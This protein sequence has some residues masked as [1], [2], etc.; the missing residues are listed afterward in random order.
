MRTGF[1]CRGFMKIEA[2]PCETDADGNVLF[3]ENGEPFLIESSRRVL[4]DWFPN[5][6]LDAGRNRMGTA[7]DWLNCCQV[8]T[9]NTN[10]LTTDTSLLGYVAGTSS[11]QETLSGAQ[12]STPYY[13]WKR[14]RY[15]F[16]VGTTAANLNEVGI[17][18]NTASGAYLFARARIVDPSGNPTTVTPLADEVLDVWYEIRYYPPLEDVTG[19]VSLNSVSYDYTIR[20]SEVN[21]SEYGSLIG[22]AIGEYSPGIGD[23]VDWIAYDGVL[24]TILQAP[25]GTSTSG[26]D[27]PTND[28]YSNNSYQR[29]MVVS[30]DPT[31]WN[32]GAFIRSIRIKTTAGRFQTQF[33]ATS[34]GGPIPKDVNF[35]MIM[36]WIISWSA[37]QVSSDWTML[38]ASDTTFPTDGEW[39]MNLSNNVLR[40]GWN[41]LSADN[42]RL[43]LRSETGTIYRIV[44]QVDPTKWVEY[45][46]TGAYTEF[47]DYTTCPVT[48]SNI[49]NGGPTVGNTCTIRN[50][51]A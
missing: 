35:T 43:G 48:Q 4:A 15:R 47:G 50:T 41:D 29:R 26:S 1:H 30:C 46:V 20:A 42:Q 44:D 12:A 16:T 21:N 3:D 49:N 27:D 19:T 5:R 33:A 40:I 10:P 18:W 45:T 28:A 51:K 11:I 9:D 6:V 37:L 2:I 25:S 23:G 31:G 39:N 17:G 24:G 7:S 32:L 13:G 38:A 22:T 36:A 8:G 14:I 34:G